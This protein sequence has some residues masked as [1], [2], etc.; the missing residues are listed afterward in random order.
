M[1]EYIFDI[2][3]LDYVEHFY[4]PSVLAEFVLSRILTKT[5]L[6][7]NPR[8]LDPACGSGI[9]LVEAFRRIVRYRIAK[10]KATLSFDELKKILKSQIGGIEINEEAARITAFSLCLSMLH[11]LEPPSIQKQIK[12]GKRL[13][14]LLT[15][16]RRTS[17]HYHCILVGNAFDTST[18]K[19]NPLWMHR[20]G[21]ECVDVIVGNPP[22]GTVDN[23][24]EQLMLEWSHSNNKSVGDKEQSQAFILRVLDFLKKGGKAGMLV[25][26]G[27]LFKH[28]TKTQL[29]RKEWLGSV[30]IR[31]VF[32]FTHVRKFF[33]KKAA[34]PF[35]SIYFEKGK[36]ADSSVLYASAKQ[37]M[38]LDKTQAV[39][40]SKYDFNWLRNQDLSSSKL[41]KTYW[42]GRF[43]D[44]TFLKSLF[45]LPQLNNIVD[46]NRTGQGYKIASR[47][48]KAKCLKPFS[49]L[50]KNIF[51]RYDKLSFCVSPRY[52]HRSGIT[53]V[54]SGPR[55]LVQRGISEKGKDKG[56]LVARYEST[57]F[58]FTNALNG[59]KLQLPSEWKYKTILG[60]LWSSF[61]RYYFFMTASTWGLWHHE[62][63]LDDELLQLPVVIEEENPA[64]KKVI[65]LVNKLI[66]YHPQKQDV[67]HPRGVPEQKVAATRRNLE[68]MLDKAVFELYELSEE[69]KDLIRDCCEIT[70][71]FFYNPFGSKGGHAAVQNDDLSWI[72]KYVNIFARRWNAY[73]DDDEE[74]RAKVYIGAHKNML[75]VEF[76]PSDKKSAWKLKATTNS[77]K[78]VLAQIGAFLPQSIGVSQILLDG[79]VSVVSKSGIIIIKRNEKRFWTRS[80][81]REDVDT[82]LAKAMK[83]GINRGENK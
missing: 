55:L 57:P 37:T 54:Y 70:L 52:V 34:S 47:D 83:K 24:R 19:N 69:Q 58:C 72:E 82:S 31:E 50:D 68:K 48:K 18:I 63:H 1:Q 75:A 38:L 73:L 22:W 76:Y 71:P 41:W 28:G 53:E 56:K 7:K 25:S 39:L 46:R 61:A 40:F 20:F 67:F 13:P 14:N 49:A 9:F 78:N 12:K 42:F 16:K 80:L 15:S 11:Y 77:W 29:F 59:I 6:Q 30:K 74:M 79:L 33:F 17:N 26:A 8:V 5:E 2:V 36:Q 81:A 45:S 23:S 60:I 65:S 62:I 51:S 32:N 3:L 66:N 64:T 43:L 35:L 44:D 21:N 27:V 10:K 4:T